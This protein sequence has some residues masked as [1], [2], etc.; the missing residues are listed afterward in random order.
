MA[1]HRARAHIRKCVL[2]THHSLKRA[3]FN[4]FKN[5]EWNDVV[6]RAYGTEYVAKKGQTEYILLG[7]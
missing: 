2:S 4:I 6:C 3:L 7:E 1:P 5:V